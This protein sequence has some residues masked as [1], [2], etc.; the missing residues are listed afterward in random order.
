VFFIR[1]DIRGQR[2]PTPNQHDDQTRLT[3]G[4]DQTVEGHGREMADDGAQCQ[5]EAPVGGQESIT[6]HLRSYRARTQDEVRQDR[7]HGFARGALDTPDG[8][9]LQ[10]DPNIMRVVRQ[11]LSATTGRLIPTTSLECVDSIYIRRIAV[12]RV[13]ATRENSFL[14]NRKACCEQSRVI[15]MSLSGYTCR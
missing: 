9:T 10:P 7:E 1:Q 11:T 14:R 13:Q 5:T 15:D 2:Q 12:F 8:Q 4:T 3:E 6:G